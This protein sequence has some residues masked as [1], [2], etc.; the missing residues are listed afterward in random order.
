DIGEWRRMEAQLGPQSPTEHTAVFYGLLWLVS[1]PPR[2]S[3]MLR[4]GG[5]QQN[6]KVSTRRHLC[7]LNGF[8]SVCPVRC[9][10]RS[11]RPVSLRA[12]SQRGPTLGAD[13]RD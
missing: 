12:S 4:R 5:G 8:Q 13:T 7:E 6:N 11:L 3:E 1:S 9:E 2:R 10:T